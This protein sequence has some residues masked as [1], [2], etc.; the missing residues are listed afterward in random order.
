MRG[1]F[2]ANIL[3]M[4]KAGLSKVRGGPVSIVYWNAVDLIFEGHY[5]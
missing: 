3:R 5:L 2:H 1:C 4:G